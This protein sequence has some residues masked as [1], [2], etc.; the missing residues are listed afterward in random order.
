MNMPVFNYQ[1]DV[2]KLNDFEIRRLMTKAAELRKQGYTYTHIAETL[3]CSV[4]YATNLVR[5]ALREII[6]DSYNEL[7][8]Q[9]TERLNAVFLPAFIEATKLDAKGEPIFNKEA[10]D[11]VIKI[12]ERRAKFLGLD[13]PTKTELSGD[14]S[15]T[16]GKPIQIYIPDNGRG[17]PVGLTIENGEVIEES[18]LVN[19][20]I[21]DLIFEEPVPIDL[22]ELSFDAYLEKPELQQKVATP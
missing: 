20:Q 19:T 12:M 14:L 16:T 17:L 1:L 3:S 21:E 18:S 6:S 5:T 11:S 13:K 22:S 4:P 9:E 2:R 15:L 7:I 8:Q 10:T